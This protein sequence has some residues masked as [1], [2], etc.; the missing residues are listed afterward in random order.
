MVGVVPMYQLRLWCGV[1][2]GLRILL[3]HILVCTRELEQEARERG[4]RQI[5]RWIVDSH[6]G[7]IGI[8]I[9]T[10]LHNQVPGAQVRGGRHKDRGSHAVVYSS[11]D[12]A[13][14]RAVVVPDAG[15]PCGIDA[16]LCEQHIEAA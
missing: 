2:D 16:W 11:H 5:D 7:G 10:A 1:D 12:A 9:G 14:H 6:S 4:M 8:W 3:A 13:I 15:D